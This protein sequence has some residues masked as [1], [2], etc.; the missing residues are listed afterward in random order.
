MVDE[1]DDFDVFPVS[2][3]G[4]SF[5]RTGTKVGQGVGEVLIA[6]GVGVVEDI[7]E[8]QVAVSDGQEETEVIGKDFDG[9]FAL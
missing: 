2:E 7:T 4:G 1:N 5:L 6:T 9:V 8:V 3:D